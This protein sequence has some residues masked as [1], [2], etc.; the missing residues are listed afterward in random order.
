MNNFAQKNTPFNENSKIATNQ[1][2]YTSSKNWVAEA[3]VI[4][5]NGSKNNHKQV[6][7]SE[8]INELVEEFFCA[9]GYGVYAHLS[10][11]EINQ[12]YNEFL[13]EPITVRDFAIRYI[14]SNSLRTI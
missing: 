12:L 1:A 6:P 3:K 5:G 9:T 13:E 8:F 4:S 7:I 11:S 10:Y 14:E 2:E